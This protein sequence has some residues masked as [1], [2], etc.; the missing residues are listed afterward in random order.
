MKRIICILIFVVS[1]FAKSFAQS[2]SVAFTNDFVL[3]EGVY[4]SYTDFRKNMPVPKDAI[5]SKEDKTQLDFISKMVADNK[6]IIILYNGTENKLETKKL[7]GYCQN[8]AVYLNYEGKFYRVPVFG[9]ISH[10][11]GTVEVYNYNNYGMYG[12][13]YG[14]MGGG[15][16]GPST[17]IKQREMRQF[18]FDFYGGEI[19]DYTLSNVEILVSRDMKLYEEFMQMKKSKRRDMMMMYVR[20]FNLAH[21]IY[22]PTK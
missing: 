6:E 4:L 22:F 7:W 10:F 1:V 17:P 3:K 9:N 2:D 18:I 21:P 20:K 5:Q 11:L 12:G 16:Y 13:M 19:M 8:N 15:M 14:G